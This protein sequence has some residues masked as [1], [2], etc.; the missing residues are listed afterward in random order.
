M[1]LAL[2]TT[3]RLFFLFILACTS[4]YAYADDY[5]ASGS[6]VCP[7]HEPCATGQTIGSIIDQGNEGQGNPVP[8]ITSSSTLTCSTSSSP[9]PTI[10][11]DANGN[12]VGQ[13]I[14]SGNN[15]Y[16]CNRT[17]R[18][19]NTNPTVTRTQGGNSISVAGNAASSLKLRILIV[20]AI[21]GIW[22]A[23]M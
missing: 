19:N 21:V 4:Q 23:L 5:Y 6:I 15:Y 16:D 12:I 11:T 1:T 22:M 7:D 18:S 8:T 10:S 9:T 17:V 14:N 2:S 13:I 20:G 3:V